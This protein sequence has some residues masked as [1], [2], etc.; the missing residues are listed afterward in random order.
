[1]PS[2]PHGAGFASER[3]DA[4]AVLAAGILGGRPTEIAE[5]TARIDHERHRGH[6]PCSGTEVRE[7]IQPL[8]LGR[9]PEVADAKALPKGAAGDVLVRTPAGVEHKIEIKAQLEKP[10]VGHFTQADWVRGSTDALRFLRFNAPEFLGRLSGPNRDELGGDA[11][12]LAGW[13]FG[14]LWLADVAG[15]TNSGLRI[16]HGVRS[17]AELGGFLQRKHLLHLCGERDLLVALSD[18]RRLKPAIADPGRVRHE[19]KVNKASECAV[20]VQVGM[21]PVV[22]TYHVYPP[23]YVPGSGL[24]GRHKLHAVALE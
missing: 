20:Q 17:A 23:G 21:G 9:F 19:L 3:A 2:K 6:C 18:L 1:M 7:R 13:D 22:F 8:L 24:V 11:E 12:D 15:L 10:L 16:L 14:G 4:I 5:A